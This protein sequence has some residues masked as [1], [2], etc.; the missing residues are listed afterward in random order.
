[1][2]HWRGAGWMGLGTARS[3]LMA[4]LMMTRILLID[5]DAELR[6]MLAD[7]LVGE[8][9]EVGVAGDGETGVPLALGGDYALVVLDVMM[10]GIGGIE[11]LKRIRASSAM[12]VVMLT[13]KGDDMDRIVGLE[14][15]ADDYVPKALHARASWLPEI[16]AILR[17]A[18][19]WGKPVVDAVQDFEGAIQAGPLQIWPAKRLA[20][21]QGGQLD[22]T[23]TEF[24]LLEF[25]G[26]ARLGSPCPSRPSPSRHLSRPLNQV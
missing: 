26:K 19:R 24:N 22:L 10:P 16:R 14:H 9:Y 13:A 8:G 5:D 23:S 11:S 3:F 25:A 15:G 7:Y 4:R 20:E 1:M 2:I 18:G 21:W 12:P 6:E 17:R